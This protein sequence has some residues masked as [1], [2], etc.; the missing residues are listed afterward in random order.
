MK[1]NSSVDRDSLPLKVAKCIEEEI[2]KGTWKDRLP[3]R[4]ILADRFKVSSKTSSAAIHLLI[5]KGV[6]NPAEKGKGCAIKLKAMSRIRSSSVRTLI[7]LRPARATLSLDDVRLLDDIRIVWE[8]TRGPVVIQDVDFEYHKQPTTLI[9][10][11]VTRYA[12][13]AFVTYSPTRTWAQITSM[14]LPT[15][16]LGG[17]ILEGLENS[18][19]A[20]EAVQESARVVSYLAD[21]GHERIF[22]PVDNLN[23]KRWVLSGLRIGLEG[24]DI[25]ADIED[26]CQ[27]FDSQDPADWM[28]FWEKQLIR[29]QPSAVVVQTEAQLLSLYGFCTRSK[30]RIPADLSVVLMASNPLMEWCYPRPT[31]MVSPNDYIIKQ[32]KQWL[33]ND[34]KPDGI[35]FVDLI[36]DEG[37]SVAKKLARKSTRTNVEAE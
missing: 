24:K 15:F 3:G 34:L 16:Q 17:S 30:I 1:R 27:I 18:S 31:M 28:R 25:G 2:A 26:F 32:F 23:Y 35:H 19:Y 29:L 21:F 14:C 13:D 20:F 5:Q 22:H 37:G 11:L 12:A 36:I 33:A 10:S 6:I 8:T 9:N 7:I 4:R